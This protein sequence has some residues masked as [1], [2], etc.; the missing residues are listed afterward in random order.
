MKLFFLL[1]ETLFINHCST[2]VCTEQNL[3]SMV[4]EMRDRFGNLC[5]LDD[6]LNQHF[7]ASSDFTVNISELV[8]RK[9]VDVCYYWERQPGENCR[10]AL[11]LVLQSSGV[12]HALVSY[13]GSL[14]KN[15]DFNIVCLS[16]SETQTVNKSTTSTGMK[17]C[18]FN[19]KLLMNT[20]YT[21]L[22]DTKNNKSKNVLCFISPKQLTIKEYFLKIIPKRIATFRLLPSTKFYFIRN[23]NTKSNV[24][25]TFDCGQMSSSEQQCES[26]QF[27]VIDDGSQSPIELLSADRNIIVAVFTRFLLNRIGGSETFRDKQDFFYSE[28]R[29]YHLKQNHSSSGRIHLK[30]NRENLLDSSIRAFKSFA[31]GDWCKKFEIEFVGENGLDWG[32]LR[33]EWVELL[34]KAFF[35]PESQT[36]LFKRF[37]NDKQGLIH[38]N[39]NSNQKQY[40]ILY[41]FAGKVVGKILLDSAFGSCKCLVNARFTRSFLAQWIGLR[42]NYRYFEQDDPDLY[43]RKIK[44]ILE[45]D[46]SMLD[47]YF[48]EEEY[49]QKTGKLYRTFDLIPNGSNTRVTEENKIRYLDALAQFRLSNSVKEQVDSFL[50]GLNDLIPDNLLSIFDENEIELLVCGAATYSLSDLRLNHVVTC[51]IY[52]FQKVVDWFWRSLAS[53]TEEEF[54]RLLQFT[55][56]CSHLPPGGFAELNPR[57]QI[58]SSLTYGNLPTA[59]TCF[60][61]ICLPD[62]N[63][64]EDLDRALRIAITEGSEGF[65]LV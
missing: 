43:V 22:N 30:I 5:L 52:D 13:K 42:V 54:A 21:S 46:V 55:T 53:F 7:D 38:P 20:N 49:D 32:G 56:G 57:F 4:V 61:Q 28:V 16:E 9:K 39:P 24:D 44:F 47:L 31:T 63:S 40:L 8:T 65:G 17:S 41:E 37:K 50:N 25:N 59:H 36:A 14:L 29:R 35:D 15:G 1:K 58:T 60:N 51:A 11:I 33:R 3:H 18:Y 6:E 64:F 12:Y 62:Y 45:N 26:D 27:I 23:Y 48:V 34:C 10:I 2:V 19:A